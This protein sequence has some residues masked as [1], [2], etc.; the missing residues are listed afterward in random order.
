MARAGARRGDPRGRVV[1]PEPGGLRVEAV[2]E[3]PVGAKVGYVDPAGAVEMDAVGVSPPLA[4][5][6]RPRA[7]V[8]DDG[9]DRAERAVGA[10]RQAGDGAG[11]VVGDDEGAAAP[12][13]DGASPAARGTIS[14]ASADPSPRAASVPTQ[15]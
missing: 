9:D 13:S 6:I 4:A 12:S 15:A 11:A 3:D 8:L 7:L 5:L 10:N 1:A 2:D 14:A